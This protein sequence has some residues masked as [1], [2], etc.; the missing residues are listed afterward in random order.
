[1]WPMSYPLKISWQEF[2]TTGALSF[3]SHAQVS[4]T[5]FIHLSD[6]KRCHFLPPAIAEK[7]VRAFVTSELGCHNSSLAGSSSNLLKTVQLSKTFIA[8][9]QSRMQRRRYI[10]PKH[11]NDAAFLCK[12][13]ASISKSF[14]WHTKHRMVRCHDTPKA[15]G[16]LI[17]PRDVTLP[18]VTF[19]LWF[20][21]WE[22]EHP[23]IRSRWRPRGR[24]PFE[25]QSSKLT[26]RLTSVMTS[27]WLKIS[28]ELTSLSCLTSAATMNNNGAFYFL[29]SCAVMIYSY[30]VFLIYFCHDVSHRHDLIP[31]FS[32]SGDGQLNIELFFNNTAS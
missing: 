1:M 32:L 27:K 16:N 31:L 17:S 11:P 19:N 10:F 25:A 24:C 22:T 20:P 23:L 26:S 4:R 6:I 2:M 30:D 21:K 18:K 15:C 7:Y 8:K 5:A 13:S 12:R 29:S 9:V 14:S 3:K 28:S